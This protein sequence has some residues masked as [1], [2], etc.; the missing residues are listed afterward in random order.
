MDILNMNVLE[1]GFI[2]IATFG[3]VSALNYFWKNATTQRNFLMSLLFAFAFSFVPADMGN[4]IANKVKD[5]VAV[6]VA[7]NGLYQML[8]GVA[9]KI[10]QNS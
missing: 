7:L 8:S 1:M 2:A 5:A 6:A 9:K 3:S 10:G 4:I